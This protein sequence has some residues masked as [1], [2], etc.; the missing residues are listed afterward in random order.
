MIEW[1]M[2]PVL[3][4]G[5]FLLAGLVKGVVGLG[6]PTVSVGLLATVMSPAEAGALL[7]IPSLVTNLWQMLVG[8]SL[9]PLLRRLWPMLVGIGLG[10]LVGS[11]LMAPAFAAAAQAG[12][13]ACLILYGAIGLLAMRPCI[14]PAWE[15]WLGPIVGAATGLVSAATG[16][17]VVPAVPYLG[18][19]ALGRDELVQALGLAFTISTLALGAGLAREGHMSMAVAGASLLA[20]APALIGMAIGG[21]LRGRV[22]LAAFRRIFFL[23]LLGLGGH[24]VLRWCL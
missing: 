17:F 6:L 3:V 15:P 7:I 24:L 2:L 20:L 13:G 12:L 22:S 16:V 8:R 14:P 21:W 10:T 18:A 19:L 23:G 5:A 1:A 4:A 11:G 9:L